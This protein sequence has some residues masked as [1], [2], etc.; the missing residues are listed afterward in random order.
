MIIR[1]WRSVGPSEG[2][3]NVKDHGQV[4]MSVESVY[5][6]HMMLFMTHQQGSA[7]AKVHASANLIASL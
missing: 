6:T 4:R 5:S 1:G 7:W 2:P 3:V